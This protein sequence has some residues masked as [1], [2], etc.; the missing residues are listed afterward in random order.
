MSSPRVSRECIKGE[1][2]TT[3]GCSQQ[4]SE[5]VCVYADK[6]IEAR[7][8]SFPRF[9]QL[10]TEARLMIWMSAFDDVD[11]AVAVYS[12]PR[13]LRRITV[14]RSH[15]ATGC[16]S[17]PIAQVCVEARAEWFRSTRVCRRPRKAQE[18]VFM[19]RTIFLVAPEPILNAR[20]PGIRRSIE[21]IAIDIAESP[22]VFKIFEALAR[23][24]R[25]R[26][27]IIII[28]SDAVEEDEV[29]LWQQR[30]RQD[31]DVLR[32]ISALVDA[33]SCDGEWHQNTYMGWLL[34]NYLDGPQV[35]HY[36]SRTGGP[37]IKLFIDRMT[38]SESEGPSMEQPWALYF[39]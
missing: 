13:S 6:P 28:P 32:R 12:F 22:D 20:L 21:H 38:S 36:Y 8:S 35:R 5:D 37:K 19:R 25:L 14:G 4:T 10:P 11:P 3:V 23:F 7:V 33:P 24:P 26:T 2:Q 15:S 16:R 31:E 17:P 39:Y 34:C 9:G 27:I 29:A 1:K 18:H 30:I